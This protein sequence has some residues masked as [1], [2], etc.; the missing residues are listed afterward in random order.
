MAVTVRS[1]QSNYMVVRRENSLSKAVH[2]KTDRTLT[3]ENISARYWK[4][5]YAKSC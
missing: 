4:L 1:R 5:L 3:H 2:A